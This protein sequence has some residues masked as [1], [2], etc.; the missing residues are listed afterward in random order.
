MSTTL[1]EIFETVEVAEPVEANGLQVFGLRRQ[2][3]EGLSYLTFEEA[4]KQGA[5]KVTEVSESGSVP[6]LL[7]KNRTGQM[8]FLMAGQQLVGAKQNRVLNASIM[9]PAQSKVTIPVSC[10]ESGRWGYRSRKFHGSGSSSHSYLRK[11]MARDA[12]EG[13]RRERRPSSQQGR[14]WAEVD[15][16]LGYLGTFSPSSALYAAYEDHR[17]RLDDTVANVRVPEGCCG[18]VFA[19]GGR[20]AGMDLFDKPETLNKL[21]PTLI[22]AYAL[23]AL[24][25]PGESPVDCTAVTT[26]LQS[27]GDAV[28]ER[29]DSPGLGDDIRVEGKALVGAGLVV[30]GCPV[31]VELFPEYD[32]DPGRGA[33]RPPRGAPAPTAA[34]AQPWSSTGSGLVVLP[35][36]REMLHLT[37][38]AVPPMREAL[39]IGLAVSLQLV[40]EERRLGAGAAAIL[41]YEDEAQ[42][43]AAA[44]ERVPHARL[45]M[46]L[47]RSGLADNWF[48]HWHAHARTAVVSVCDWE[49]LSP[50]PAAA[51]VAQELVL[52]GSRLLGD[53]DPRELFHAE[54]R[55]C[56]FDFCREKADVN[57]RLRY[58]EVCP[59][60]Q[61]RLVAMRVNLRRVHAALGRVR[62]LAAVGS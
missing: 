8:V 60:C 33:R 36:S 56:L 42:L 15:R 29:Y 35:T 54:T 41:S 12:L 55:G 21:L 18:A 30:D 16:K 45:R 43:V 39:G 53:C 37:S 24:E 2:P 19:F 14:V 46:V 51:F 26:W 23:D 6:T 62:D 20:P 52:H 17:H 50:L 59:Q 32:D 48:S 3:A 4:I 10:V 31:H 27:S 40:E 61:E 22:R 7:V 9:V 11:L 13:Y 38:D 25:E 28:F 49:R 44:F 1:K 58:G 57:H 34:P 5:F 47:T